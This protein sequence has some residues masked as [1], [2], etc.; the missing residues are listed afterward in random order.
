MEIEDTLCELEK[1]WASFCGDVANARSQID[2]C[3][4]NWAEY[5][6]NFNNLKG[7][8]TELNA[9]Y[10]QDCNDLMDHENIQNSIDRYEVKALNDNNLNLPSFALLFPRLYPS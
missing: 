2:R 3:T 1:S 7:M 9:L 10:D 5:Q 6:D 4:A 8:L